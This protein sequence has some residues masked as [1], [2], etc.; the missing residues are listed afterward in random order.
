[1]DIAN[2]NA[3]VMMVSTGVISIAMPP[4]MF[5]PFHSASRTPVA[6]AEPDGEER[7]RRDL[8]EGRVRQASFSACSGQRC[9]RHQEHD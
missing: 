1:M 3:I 7:Q 6:D 5:A 9:S 4:P 8:S 2:T